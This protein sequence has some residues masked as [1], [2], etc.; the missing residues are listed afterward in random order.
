MFA[1]SFRDISTWNVH[2]LPFESRKH[3]TRYRARF[4]RPTMFVV[5]SFAINEPALRTINSSVY[6]SAL[7]NAQLGNNRV[8]KSHAR[9]AK[10][11]AVSPLHYFPVSFK[12]NF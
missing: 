7:P 5:F 4:E 12:L 3:L 8:C 1:K 10:Y 9:A 11:R 6:D 2:L